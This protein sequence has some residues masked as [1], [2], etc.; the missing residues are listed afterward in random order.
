MVGGVGGEAGDFRVYF[1]R[2]FPDPGAGVHGASPPGVVVPYS[3]SHL[4]TSAP[5]GLTLATTSLR[6][7][8]DRRYSA[9]PD[10]WGARGRFGRFHQRLCSCRRRLLPRS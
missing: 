2:A 3:N 8:G 5:L 1:D 7:L 6:G 4:V 9:G 10:R